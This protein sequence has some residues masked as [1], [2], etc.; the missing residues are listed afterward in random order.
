M[1]RVFLCAALIPLSALAVVLGAAAFGTAIDAVTDRQLEHSR[2]LQQ[3]TN[4]LDI[5]RCR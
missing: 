4:G 2:C 3:A 1:K 5:E